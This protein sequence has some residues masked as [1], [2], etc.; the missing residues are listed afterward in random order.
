[1]VMKLSNR[2]HARR[3]TTRRPNI[4]RLTEQVSQLTEQPNQLTEQV[5]LLQKAALFDGSKVL[6]L[7]RSPHALSRPSAWD[8]PGGNS[9]WPSVNTESLGLH[10]QDIAREI[11]EE[12]GLSL[13]PDEFQLAN[14]KFFETHFDA[15][16]Q[17]FTITVGWHV[18][19]FMGK[20]KKSIN[21]SQEHVEWA[22]VNLDKVGGYDFGGSNGDWIKT[23]INT[24]LVAK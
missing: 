14:L 13:S 5:K 24:R 21:L 3:S 7:K 9:E 11:K 2:S 18:D 15:D 10:R 23:I 20:Q 4:R 17:V 22:W 1:M 16:K 6:L 12:T 19:F 8:L